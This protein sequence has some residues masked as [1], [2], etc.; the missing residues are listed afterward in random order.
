MCPKTDEGR[1]RRSMVG[2]PD[3]VF[4]FP[5]PC[6]H[7]H[8][9]LNFHLHCSCSD[10]PASLILLPLF[11]SSMIPG[12]ALHLLISIDCFLFWLLT[13]WPWPDASWNTKTGQMSIMSPG[14]AL[15]QHTQTLL[16]PAI[17]NWHSLWPVHAPHRLW[18][19]LAHYEMHCS[20]PVIWL[21]QSGSILRKILGG[22]KCLPQLHGSR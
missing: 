18:G 11:G 17:T 3:L 5:F 16:C 13:E 12:L 10:S 22:D 21:F 20:F 4:S 6:L 7:Y 2:Q 8:F 14:Q 1:G 9:P 19:R 15:Q